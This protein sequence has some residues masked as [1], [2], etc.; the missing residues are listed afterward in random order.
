MAFEVVYTKSAVRDIRKLDR[1]VKK[2]I[3]KRIEAYSKKPLFYARK[4]LDSRIGTYR[5][6][7]GNYRV[8]FDIDKKNIVILRIRH[9]REV[10]K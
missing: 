8:I 2:K 6:R 4:L 5:W 7:V 1:V 9:R 10:Y 3:K